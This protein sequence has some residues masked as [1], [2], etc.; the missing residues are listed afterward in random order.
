MRG[1]IILV[2]VCVCMIGQGAA[3]QLGDAPY[4]FLDPGHF[5][6]GVDI[7]GEGPFPFILDTGATRTVVF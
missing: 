5:V 1:L 3:R 6:V 2:T 4:R 7:N